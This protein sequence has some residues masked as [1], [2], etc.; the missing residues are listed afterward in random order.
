[1]TSL[2]DKEKAYEDKFAHDQ[3]VAFL[4]HARRNKLLGLWVAEKIGLP[5]EKRED[6]A[7]NI[8][9]HLEMNSDDGVIEHIRKDLENADIR[10]SLHEIQEQLFHCHQDAKKHIMGA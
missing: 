5:L 10:F 7:K 3:E 8:V 2:H 1:M 4:I 6:Y 9:A